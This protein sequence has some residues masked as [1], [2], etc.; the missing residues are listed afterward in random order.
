LSQALGRRC[1]QHA[2]EKCDANFG[3]REASPPPV[4]LARFHLWLRCRKSSGWR[5]DSSLVI[6]YC[7]RPLL[8]NNFHDLAAS[9]IATPFGGYRRPVM[10]IRLGF[11]MIY[12]CPQPPLFGLRQ[13]SPSL[14]LKQT[15][16]V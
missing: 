13:C 12:D 4:R 15:S 5:R 7:T 2:T 6:P 16:S 10:Q 9:H 11:E 3:H 8:V 14:A 1:A